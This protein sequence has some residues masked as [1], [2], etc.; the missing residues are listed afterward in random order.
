M[1]DYKEEVLEMIDVA[2][3]ANNKDD[4]CQCKHRK[5][6]EINRPCTYCKINIALYTARVCIVASVGRLDVMW[7]NMVA[8]QVEIE[9]KLKR[10]LTVLLL[11]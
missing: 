1:S 7:S 9:K 10:I 8:M 2:L 6:L 4:F 5:A 11:K 3:A